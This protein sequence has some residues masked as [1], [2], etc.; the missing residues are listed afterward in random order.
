[1]A[2]VPRTRYWV[3]QGRCLRDTSVSYSHSH[4]EAT[5]TFDRNAIGEQNFSAPNIG[6]GAIGVGLENRT[7][8]CREPRVAVHANLRDVTCGVLAL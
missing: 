2:A 3:T 6:H 4:I 1:M 5:H 8:I 7:C